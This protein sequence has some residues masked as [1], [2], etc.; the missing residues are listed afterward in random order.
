MKHITLIFVLVFGF[1]LMQAQT[2]CYIKYT[3][4]DAGNRIKREFVCQPYEPDDDDYIPP[5]CPTPVAPNNNNNINT[6]TNNEIFYGAKIKNPQDGQNYIS[7]GGSILYPIPSDNQITIEKE[8]ANAGILTIY[9][10]MGQVV[11]AY[12]LN[13][14]LQKEILSTFSIPD[15][16]YIYKIQLDHCSNTNGKLQI[17]H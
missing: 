4:D 15:G 1:N 13:K 11:I 8:C 3:Y 2:P 7:R 9:N 12:A 10:A 17:K 14:G 6:G 5:C 16:N